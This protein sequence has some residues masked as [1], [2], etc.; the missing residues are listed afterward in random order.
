MTKKGRKPGPLCRRCKKATAT[1]NAWCDE[2]YAEMEREKD[3][4][5]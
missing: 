1:V 5:G 2:C 3:E 4:Q